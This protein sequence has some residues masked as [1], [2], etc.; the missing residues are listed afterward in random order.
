MNEMFP[1]KH[2]QSAMPMRPLCFPSTEAVDYTAL[3]VMKKWQL[4]TSAANGF[5]QGVKTS[6]T[7][8]LSTEWSRGSVL[9]FDYFVT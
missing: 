9:I 5:T 3:L 1:T 6:P 4:V 8:C 7:E 2:S